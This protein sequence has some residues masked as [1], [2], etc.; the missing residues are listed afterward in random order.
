MSAAQLR[1]EIQIELDNME[2]V[3]R[4]LGTLRL[5]VEG[6]EPTVRERTAASGFLVQFYNGV[7][8]ILKR[9]SR[10][11]SVLLPVGENWHVDLF[12]RFCLP[13]TAPLP[14]LFDEELAAGLAPFRKFRQVVYRGYGFQF[15]WAR[16]TEGLNQVERLFAHFKARL[17]EYLRNLEPP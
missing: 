3:V 5:D 13:M 6:R 9:I 10:Y 1:E 15:D 4:E 16:M 11:H 14:A 7:E 2:L 17:E 8:N 12:K